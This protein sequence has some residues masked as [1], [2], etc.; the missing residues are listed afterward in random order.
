MVSHSKLRKMLSTRLGID[1]RKVAIVFPVT[2]FI[3]FSYLDLVRF[4][5]FNFYLDFGAYLQAIYTTAFYGKLLYENYDAATI[6][7][8]EGIPYFGSYLGIH[9]SP[10]LFIF[11]PIFRVF[12]FPETLIILKVLAISLSIFFA[13]KVALAFLKSA[14]LAFIATLLYTLHPAL[15][16]LTLFDFQPQA[17]FPLFMFLTIYALLKGKVVLY[18]LSLIAAL[19]T[20]EFMSILICSLAFVDIVLKKNTAS[21]F[22]KRKYAAITFITALSWYIMA[23]LIMPMFKP[24]VFSPWTALFSGGIVEALAYGFLEKVS[25]FLM[26]ILPFGFIPLRSTYFLALLPYLGSVFT[27][28]YAGLFQLGWHYGSYFLPLMFIALID[29][30]SKVPKLKVSKTLLI[31]SIAVSVFLSPLNPITAG[32]IPGAAYDPAPFNKEHIN[33]IFK[34][35]KL[36]PENASILVQTPLSQHLAMNI[37][38]YTWV[39][40]IEDYNIEYILADIKHI[41]FK[42]Y[43]FN[44]LIPQLLSNRS[45]GLYAYADGIILLRKNYTG[46]PILYYPFKATFKYAGLIGGKLRVSSGDLVLG[47][48]RPVIDLTSKSFVVVLCR[49]A[50]E[51]PI[52]VAWYGPYIFLPPGTYN[53]TFVLKVKK[54]SISNGPI[55]KL[56]VASNKGL[57]IYSSKIITFNDIGNENQW[58]NATLTFSL[59][60]FVD[61]IEFRGLNVGRYDVYLDYIYVEQV[62]LSI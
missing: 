12:P 43:G 22:T 21:I 53:V 54:Y 4:Y 62:K 8:R 7:L 42:V 18:F 57:T 29:S 5:N 59:N 2:Y 3:V 47:D 32:N 28:T 49:G 60:S 52:D 38:A 30:L 34:V 17:F 61:D 25:Y 13:Y 16:S 1:Y 11:V 19:S 37:N 33:Y 20:N 15:H 58:V 23:S 35:F 10:I 31:I 36:I 45:Y 41:D 44:R 26:I 46:K 39:P 55:M 9:F 14:K 56:D 51:G 27:S 40:N 48:S 50:A 6:F 24:R